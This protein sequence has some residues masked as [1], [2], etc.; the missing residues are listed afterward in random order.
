MPL[1]IEK[2]CPVC[3]VIFRFC[4]HC[5]RGHKYCGP[6]CSLEGRKRNRRI[7]EKKYAATKKGRESR[8]RRQKNFRNRSILGLKV[9]DH[10]PR[11]TS[12]IIRHSSNSVNKVSKRCKH[13]QKLLRAIIPGGHCAV[14]EEN[15]YFSFI[16][17]RSRADRIPF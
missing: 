11:V 4:E 10:S 15:N 5:W 17:F 14:T 3:R 9:T 16:R 2:V 7:T 12:T 6:S 1:G 13:C 8:R